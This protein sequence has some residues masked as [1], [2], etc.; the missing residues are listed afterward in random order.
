MVW[1]LLKMLDKI[2]IMHDKEHVD[3]VMANVRTILGIGSNTK[4]LDKYMEKY[5]KVNEG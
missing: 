3:N 4:K 5:I 2:D 1:L